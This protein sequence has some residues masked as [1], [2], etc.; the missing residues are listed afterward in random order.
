MES[1]R[2]MFE[3]RPHNESISCNNYFQDRRY[4]Y[5]VQFFVGFVCDFGW[6]RYISRSDGEYFLVALKVA[7]RDANVRRGGDSRGQFCAGSITPMEKRR[8]QSRTSRAKFVF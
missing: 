1:Q 4:Q 2:A 6:R 8:T 3:S 7:V 5:A